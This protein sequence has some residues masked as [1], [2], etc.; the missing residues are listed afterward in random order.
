L[1]LALKVARLTGRYRGA[2]A[3]RAMPESGSQTA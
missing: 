3:P 1:H 2:A